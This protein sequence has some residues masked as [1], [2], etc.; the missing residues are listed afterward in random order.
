MRYVLVDLEADS[1]HEAELE[2]V[3]QIGVVQRLAQSADART[4]AVNTEGRSIG[5]F[6]RVRP[7]HMELVIPSTTRQV[8]EIW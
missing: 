4:V 1:A 5:S 8:R 6:Y 2:A 3:L 7:F